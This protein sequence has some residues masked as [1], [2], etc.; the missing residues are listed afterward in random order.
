[1]AFQFAT[2][3][4]QANDAIIL[5]TDGSAEQIKYNTASKEA[6]KLLNG[7]PTIIGE[8]EQIQT[9]IVQSLNQTN[10]GE[11]NKHTLPVPF[12]NKHNGNYLLYRVDSKGIAFNLSL[13]QYEHF[14]NPT[15]SEIAG[16][17][18]QSL[19]KL[20]ND[21]VLRSTSSPMNGPE[22]DP[23]DDDD[24]KNKS[25]KENLNEE[26]DGDKENDDDID[27]EEIE[28]VILGEN[29]EE[30]E[31][32]DI[33]DELNTDILFN[34]ITDFMKNN[35]LIDSNKLN[36]FKTD[37]IS[38]VQSELDKFRNICIEYNNSRN[39][40]EETIK[41]ITLNFKTINFD[42][43]DSDRNDNDDLLK[44]I[45]IQC[46]KEAAQFMVRFVFI[47][48]IRRCILV[49]GR[50]ISIIFDAP[51]QSLCDPVKSHEVID[52]ILLN[53]AFKANIASSLYGINAVMW[54][55]GNLW[56]LPKQLELIAFRLDNDLKNLECMVLM[57]GYT[58]YVSE[59]ENVICDGCMYF[60]RYIIINCCIK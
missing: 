35:A 15:D 53:S 10:C 38:S 55:Q 5:K 21:L 42:Q 12:C 56:N 31:L 17:V 23:N 11:L 45:D 24:D 32:F 58:N 16:K 1:M 25:I 20:V 29:I 22:Y 37:L 33:D 43:A 36:S 13:K 28:E 26:K 4:S 48:N 44:A 6:N 54:N 46:I 51:Y 2:N 27:V 57:S 59:F 47:F 14:K 50:R 9:I 18:N 3:S 52:G 41:N 39:S 8:L 30:E 40:L 49:N 19:Q 34:Q 7:R 60:S